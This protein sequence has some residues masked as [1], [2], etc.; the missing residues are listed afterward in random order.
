MGRQRQP[1]TRQRLLDACTDHAL[2]QGLPD[3]LG[4]WA[5]AAGP[6]TGILTNHFGPRDG[7]LREV[8]GQ[9]RR[10]QVEAFTDLIRLRPDEPYPTTLA[11][12]WSAISGPQGEPYLRMFG[13]LHDT[14]G[15]PLWPGFRRTA[16][17]DWLAPLE[18]G[19]R[20]LG[21]TELATVAR[22]VIRGLLKDLDATGDTA[23]TDRAFHDFLA[24]ID[25]A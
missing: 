18:E 15:E 3:R 2:E 7:L 11:R 24:T 16:T 17:T 9:A 5:A 20:S 13:R 6:S 19:M 1:Q 22:A 25:S 12:A 21:R 4:P 14:A 23:R 8:L 10:R